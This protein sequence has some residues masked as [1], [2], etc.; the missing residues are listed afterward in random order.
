MNEFM[1]QGYCYSPPFP[2]TEPKCTSMNPEKYYFEM[3]NFEGD[4][5]ESVFS[6][7]SLNHQA[8]LRYERLQHCT[9]VWNPDEVK[10]FMAD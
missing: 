9:K 2:H 6:A 3:H 8:Y 7:D 10:A 4:M 5:Y 1:R